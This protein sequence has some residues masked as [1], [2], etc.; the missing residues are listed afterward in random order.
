MGLT[1]LKQ[2]LPLT[3]PEDKRLYF[4][5]TGSDAVDSICGGI[6]KKHITVV[7]GSSGCGKSMLLMNMSVLLAD[8][9]PG[10]RIAYLS[11]ENDLSIDADRSESIMKYYNISSID[12][13]TYYNLS[14]FGTEEF[15]E[16][17]NE[18]CIGSIENYDL[19]V[20]DGTE[21]I[22]SDQPELMHQEG[23]RFQAKLKEYSI[24]YDTTFILSWQNAKNAFAKKFKDITIADMSGSSAL[25]TRAALVITVGFEYENERR[26]N[27]IRCLKSRCGIGESGYDIRKIGCWNN[28]FCLIDILDEFNLDGMK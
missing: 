20:I 26:Q 17:L 9:N 13:L 2:K 8:T 3:L 18:I 11:V 14:D 28:P 6:P 5:K 10:M 7:T 21:L 19:V 27:E 22:I 25:A 16:N 12:N 24:N 15:Y 4:Y 1:D 23:E